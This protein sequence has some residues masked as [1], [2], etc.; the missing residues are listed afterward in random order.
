MARV[1]FL[2]LAL[3]AL[4]GCS[5][6]FQPSEN[7][8][9]AGP[10]DGSVDVEIDAPEDAPAD[11][12]TDTV[13]GDVGADADPCPAPVMPSD[14]SNPACDGRECNSDE[15]CRCV[16]GFA[17][18]LYC[19]AGEDNDGDGLFDCDDP[20]CAGDASCCGEGE[21]VGSSESWRQSS[22]DTFGS[23]PTIDEGEESIQFARSEVGVA[24][25]RRCAVVEGGVTADVRFT[26]T[27]EECETEPCDFA[28][29]GFS[30]LNTDSSGRFESEIAVRVDHDG[31]VR[32][33]RGGRTI[34]E[35]SVNLPNGSH[36]I[37]LSIQPDA[38]GS[39]TF[40]VTGRVIPT[41]GGTTETFT[42]PGE[43]PRANLISDSGC[44]TLGAGLFFGMM[45]RGEAIELR[46]SSVVRSDCANPN[47]F[48]FQLALSADELGL[49]ES[50]SEPNTPAAWASESL[51]TAHYSESSEPSEP[52]II[53]VA[54]SNEQ[55]EL[56]PT[57][58]IGF[59]LGKS[60]FDGSSWVSV[61]ADIATGGA[62]PWAGGNPPSCVLSSC[63]DGTPRSIVDPIEF[64]SSVYVAQEEVPGS[65]TYVLGRYN[66]DGTGD[67][68]EFTLPAIENCESQRD[69]FPVA[70]GADKELYFTC[71]PDVGAPS[72]HVGTLVGSSTNLVNER[73]LISGARD[74]SVLRRELDGETNYRLWYLVN[75]DGDH[76]VHVSTATID[77]ASALAATDLAPLGA[78]PVL[79]SRSP[80]F[81]S[82]CGS[83]VSCT[84]WG[85]TATERSGAS[86]GIF[87]A[88]TL[89]MASALGREYQIVVVD[90]DWSF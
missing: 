11:T 29:W 78:N 84:I 37:Q 20:D 35:S 13:D 82:V 34:W 48:G 31:K 3:S 66:A 39:A 55:V 50:N 71:V 67:F 87:G 56:G 68:V 46:E 22:F 16:F 5:I 77:V 36:Q 54:A 57:V 4:S 25:L 47:Q 59:A 58:P 45:G 38:I 51:G 32:L 18:E 81:S 70:N 63:P 52:N 90:Q 2:S 89:R 6:L 15:G 30:P 73:L 40:A 72:I 60:E 21:V 62:L 28:E 69:P 61:D 10:S 74:P 12:P 64:Q 17:R 14:C 23:A 19:E 44:S 83:G 24:I 80:A 53:Y 65:G 27:T 76:E 75:A 86:G 49:V 85:F 42:L 79:R 88:V 26:L 43:I 1:V 8:Y 33:L 7:F 41:G 9:D